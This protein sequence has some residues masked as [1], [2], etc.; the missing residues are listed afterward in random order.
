MSASAGRIATQAEPG[1]GESLPTTILARLTATPAWLQMVA[2]ALLIAFYCQ[3]VWI[4]YSDS[5]LFRRIGFDWGLFYGQAT[6][7]AAGDV[8]A[9]YQVDRLGE[10]V[11]RLA[12]YTTA[13]A[14]PLLQWPSPYPP[15][16][17]GALEPLTRMPPP[18]AFG[19]W[20]CLSLAAAL[21]LVWRISQLV[22]EGGRLRLAVIFF[23][24]LAVVQAFALGQP[25]VLLA[26]AMGE[27]YLSLRSGADFR[28]GMWLGLIA[29]KPQYG[30]LLGVFLLWKRRWRAVLGACVTALALVAASALVAGPQALLDY[31]AAVQAMSDFRNPYAAAAEMVNWRAL[32]VNARPS[33]GNESGILLFA[34]LSAATVAA[35]VWSTRGEWRVGSPRLEWQLSAVLVGTF[36]VSY[37]SHMHG[38]VLLAVPVAAMWRLSTQLPAVKLSVLTFV[39]LP[40]VVFVIVAGLARGFAINYED[41]LWIVWPVVNV[42]VLVLLLAATMRAVRFT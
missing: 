10:Y 36:L 25:V 35:I 32:I 20:T 14:E 33:I 3:R 7:L 34:I 15:V 13:P 28:G 19:L 18:L 40:T 9:M 8:S 38:L 21:H 23:T 39:F 5:G 42:M 41:P 37:H 22:P 30:L 17:A 29:L 4:V 26:V 11:Q 16:L 24:T 6:A 1:R 27:A 2:G 12:A 31:A